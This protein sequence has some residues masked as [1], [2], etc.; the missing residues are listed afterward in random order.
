MFEI[1]ILHNW[2]QYYFKC[3]RFDGMRLNWDN[4]PEFSLTDALGIGHTIL[5]LPMRALLKAMDMLQPVAEYFN[6]G[7]SAGRSTDWMLGSALL[8]VLI[9]AVVLQVTGSKRV[10]KSKKI[11]EAV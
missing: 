2:K 3:T 1:E 6:V 10:R 5:M 8:W 7:C 4:S 9:I 11:A